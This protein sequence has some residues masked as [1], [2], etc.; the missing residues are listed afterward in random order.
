MAA[1]EGVGYRRREGGVRGEEGKKK[2]VWVVVVVVASFY[3][4]GPSMR[5]SLILGNNCELAYLGPSWLVTS[6]RR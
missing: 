6:K 3:L 5:E 4:G 1:G 2:K